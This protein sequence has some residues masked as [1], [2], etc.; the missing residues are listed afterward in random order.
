MCS[1]M[2]YA[3]VLALSSCFGFSQWWTLTYIP[4]WLCL[5]FIIWTEHVEHVLFLGCLSQTCAM[6]LLGKAVETLGDWW[7]LQVDVRNWG[8]LWGFVARSHP[9]HS[10]LPG[11][12]GNVQASL[13]ILQLCLLDIH[14]S[15]MFL[16]ARTKQTICPLRHSCQ[17]L[18]L[19]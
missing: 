4:N 1:S 15:S 14:E 3:S 12:Q 16:N 9:L 8:W 11:C 17:F 13:I 6:A 7:V 5:V 2:V 18:V 19:L 10:V